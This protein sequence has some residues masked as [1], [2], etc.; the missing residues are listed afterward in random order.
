MV[1]CKKDQ[2]Y[3][4]H[5]QVANDDMMSQGYVQLARHTLSSAIIIIRLII[6]NLPKAVVEAVPPPNSDLLP[7]NALVPVAVAPKPPVVDAVWPNTTKLNAL[8]V[9]AINSEVKLVN[10]SHDGKQLY[11]SLLLDTE[12]VLVSASNT[13]SL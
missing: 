5:K 2:W 6:N 3:V 11:K 7:P 9:L 12:L 10:I 13:I 8:L 4:I 1:S